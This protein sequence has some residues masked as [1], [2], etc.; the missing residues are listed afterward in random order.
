[1]FGFSIVFTWEKIGNLHHFSTVRLV[2]GLSI[3]CHLG[4][5]CSVK[6]LTVPTKQS[7]SQV[8]HQSWRA[9]FLDSQASLQIKVRTVTVVSLLLLCGFSLLR[10]CTEDTTRY[11]A[12]EFH[13]VPESTLNHDIMKLT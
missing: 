13:I 10:L 12:Y 2:E 3:V 6:G 5:C 8:I 11:T 9:N 4:G 7:I 1:M